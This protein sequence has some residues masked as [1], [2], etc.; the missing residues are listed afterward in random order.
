MWKY[1]TTHIIKRNVRRRDR[2]REKRFIPYA[3]VRSVVVFAE[4]QAVQ[5]LLPRLQAMAADGKKVTLCLCTSA[6]QPSG[7]T[8]PGIDTIELA[9][10]DLCHGHTRPTSEACQKILS[11]GCDA[12][13]DLTLADRLPLSYLMSLSAAPLHLGGKKDT[14]T[15]AD[16][17]IQQNAE[18]LTPDTLLQN[19]LFYWKN[20]AAK[21]NNS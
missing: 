12:V 8:F 13:V 21:N 16:I 9:R 19:L 5:Q 1:I 7:C 11:L 15:P 18:D 4:P 2:C 14:L 10:P 6:A 17:M 20:I 3:A